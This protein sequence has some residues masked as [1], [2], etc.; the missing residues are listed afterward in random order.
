[1]AASFCVFRLALVGLPGTLSFCSRDLLIH[2]T[3]MSHAATGVVLPIAAAM[4]A[5]SIF[6]LFARLFLGKR[7]TRSTHM[8]DAPPRERW[9][10]AAGILFIVLGGIFPN[11]IVRQRFAET[12]TIAKGMRSAAGRWPTAAFFHDR[13][14]RAVRWPIAG[15]AGSPNG[16][17]AEPSI[18]FQRNASDAVSG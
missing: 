15:D 8:A 6:R 7:R 1:M 3:L 10:L 2:G 4:N 17:P 13:E 16:D 11:L 14:L 5:V 9:I 18:E 12:N